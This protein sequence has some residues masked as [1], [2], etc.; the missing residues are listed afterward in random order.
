MAKHGRTE[1]QKRPKRLLEVLP[2]LLG[3]FVLVACSTSN[4]N[5]GTAGTGQSIR[6]AQLQSS[7]Y[8]SAPTAKLIDA[9]RH[10]TGD[11]TWYES[12]QQGVIAPVLAAFT[13]KYPFVHINHVPLTGTAVSSRV[14][15]ESAAGSSTADVA[16]AGAS[17]VYALQQRNL[18]QAGNWASGGI[19]KQLTPSGYTSVIAGQPFGLVYNP[20]LVKSSDV[21]GSWEDLLK[22]QWKGR[23]V[24]IWLHATTFAN[25]VTVWQPSKTQDYVS[26]LIAQQPVVL[27]NGQC[28]QQVGAGAMPIGIA[29]TSETLQAQ[30][31]GSPVQMKYP[32]PVPTDILVNGIPKDAKRPN[33]ARLLINWLSSKEGSQ[34]YEKNVL[35]GNL[36][37]PDT[38]THQVVAG[39][40]VAAWAPDAGG[41]EDGW[42]K[43]FTTALQHVQ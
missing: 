31:T 25:L 33:T 29:P 10:E 38:T 43:K 14:A 19:P 37:L 35:R 16:S 15:Q 1:R 27:P 36:L 32:D 39:H 13:A 41:Q 6:P 3:L 17:T 12:S 22:P 34:I 40:T 2:A 20:K 28:A 26:K 42:V 8:A 11:L 7:G 4:A 21:P 5:T 18:L 9:A 23:K 30:K 24:C